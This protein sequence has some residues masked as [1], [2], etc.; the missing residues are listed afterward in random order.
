MKDK[1]EFWLLTTLFVVHFTHIF[2]FVIMMPLGPVL[3]KKLGLGPSEFANI[4]SVYAFAA[5]ISSFFSSFWVDRF[6][7][8][9]ALIM[10]YLGFIAGNLFCANAQSYHGLMLARIVAGAFGG[11]L[12]GITFSIVGDEIPE[13]RRG[14]A[15]GIVMSAF[16][17]SSVLGV[18]VGILMA[19]KFDWHAPFYFIAIICLFVLVVIYFKIYS[20]KGHFNP[21]ATGIKFIEVLKDSNHR[22]ALSLTVCLVFAGFMVIPFVS[23]Y[24]VANVGLTE[25]ELAYLYFFGGFFTFMTSR[26]IGKMSDK[27]GKFKVF[28]VVAFASILPILINTNMPRLP[29]FLVIAL[30]TLFFILVSGRFVPA[31]AIITSSTIRSLRGAFMGV[32]T[33]VQSLAM[34]IASSIGGLII[35]KNELGEMTGYPIVGFI[36]CFF[37]LISIVLAKRVQINQ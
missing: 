31:M 23:P 6:D 29:L 1:K 2:D 19:N 7:R 5:A 36:A 35:G 32:N 9:T 30:N 28:K 26:M 24:M 25:E 33:S 12:G 34:G 22:K 17:I 15:T 4:V 8:K 10:V 21:D 18:P 14:H 3:M 16:S 37:T 27:F 11:V 13:E 20:M